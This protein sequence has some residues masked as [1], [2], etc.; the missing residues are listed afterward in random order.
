M[1]NYK[2]VRNNQRLL[3]IAESERLLLELSTAE[4]TIQ[5]CFRIMESTCLS[6]GIYCKID[7]KSAAPKFLQHLDEFYT[8]FCR[9]AIRAMCVYGFVPWRTMKNSKGDTIPEVLPAGTFSWFTELNSKKQ[10]QGSMV[11][12]RVQPAGGH[13]KESEVEIYV[14]TQPSLDI[15]SYSMLYATITSPLAHILSDY[16]A[17]R[18]AQLRRSHADAWNTTAKVITQFDPKLRVEDNPT[19]Y[20][21]D[22]VHEDYYAPPPGAESMFP[23]LE[24]HNVWQREQIIRRQFEM[25]PSVHHPEVF[26]LPRDHTVAQQTHL[27]PCEDISFL[28]D[29]YKR[30]VCSLLGIPYEMIQGKDTSGLGNENIRKTLASGRMFSTNMQDY[31]KH[32]QRLL[33]NVYHQ[34]YKN[35]TY[36]EF[37]LIPMP[38]LEIECVADLK[39]LHEIGALTPDM[40]LEMSNTLL[41]EHYVKK[42]KKSKVDITDMSDTKNTDG[43]K[44]NN[45]KMS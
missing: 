44:N 24:A 7:G 42:N 45:K 27:E 29:K 10:H 6:Q 31:C 16:K 13:F 9:A 34:I 17:L 20:L 41:G 1:N 21:M 5:Q 39:V 8:P 43:I 3:D 14:H 25:N 35:D 26:A 15:M 33:Q 23:Q 12:Y 4:P 38:R 40:S 37:C 2:K 32:L 22:F 19:Q 28:N 36:V 30:D 18:Q 11:H